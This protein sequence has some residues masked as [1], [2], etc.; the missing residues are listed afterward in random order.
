MKSATLVEIDEQVV[1]VAKKA[2]PAFGNAWIDPRAEVVITDAFKWMSDRASRL[3][4]SL[5]AVFFDLLDIN[6]PSPLLDSIFAGDSLG[7]FVSHARQALR[8]DGFAVF[9]LGESGEDGVT[10]CLSVGGQEDN[11]V[12][13]LRQRAFELEL[14]R[15]FKSVIIY[16][17]YVPSFLGNWVFALATGDL[18]LSH[19]WNRSAAEIDA[20]VAQRVYQHQ[21][22]SWFRGGSAK[23]LRTLESL[24]PSL[25]VQR[26]QPAPPAPTVE[27]CPGLERARENSP[28]PGYE[29]PYV[30][31]K[32]PHA[33]GILVFSLRPIRRGEVIWRKHQESF[34]ELTPA[35]WRELVFSH[36]FAK[37]NGVKA[38]LEKDW[39][40]EYLVERED[41]EDGPAVTK[42]FME[43]DDA[44][45][46]NHGYLPSTQE[47]F[48][49]MAEEDGASASPQD[50]K[51]GRA[52][53]ATR[54]IDACEEILEDYQSG[55]RNLEASTTVRTPAWWVEVLKL[56]GLSN[57]FE[58]TPQTG[59]FLP[60][61]ALLSAP[62]NSD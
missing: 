13:E 24:A 57:K 40:N 35:N 41:N 62:A 9:Q 12:G 28:L 5:D 51:Y 44:R 20:D 59:S 7:K 3:P 6:V 43:L 55:G 4:A 14:R 49:N 27:S 8:D 38:F 21:S 32:S 34:R 53:I 29:I 36:P 11:C 47:A 10:P 18:E 17:Q 56:Y 39:V 33:H 19:R 52:I 37:E 45:F 30:L 60:E 1:Q 48:S 46:T 2:F 15:R 31:A 42:M 54:D 50:Y 16:T 23:S 61:W 22:L 58:F 25:V 26:Y